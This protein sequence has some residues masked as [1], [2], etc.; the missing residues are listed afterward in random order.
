VFSDLSAYAIG[1]EKLSLFLLGVGVF[2][3]SLIFIL[4][5]VF[6][7]R[8]RRKGEE[9]GGGPTENL[10]LEILWG[11]V[12]FLIM[13]L[14]FVWGARLYM[15]LFQAEDH[16]Q[17]VSVLAKRWMW[18]FYYPGGKE[19]VNRLYVPAGETTQLMMISQDVIHSFFV[20]DLRM[21]K[22]VLPGRYI[23]LNL[24]P[25]KPGNYPI[26]C[27]EYCGTDH[28]QMGARLIVLPPKKFE[29]WL[30][31]S[32]QPAEEMISGRGRRLFE[33]HQCASCHREGDTH[34]GPDLHGIFGKE[35]SL[36]GGKKVVVDEDY[37]RTSILAPE[38]Q[39]HQGYPS[40]MPP[41][42]GQF[43]EEELL[44]LIKYLKEGDHD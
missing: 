29:E 2:F 32:A 23:R 21:K 38:A 18:K 17:N 36:E 41:Y 34:L 22:D 39:I 16:Q 26:R 27:A 3:S 43:T 15:Q 42:Q 19:E 11:T 28:S 31:S 25:L 14:I 9:R 5:I 30:K 7:L 44:S 40:A 8:Y 12:P 35:I 24:H 4:M 20:P 1:F 13:I 33:K 37:L 10:R 6:C